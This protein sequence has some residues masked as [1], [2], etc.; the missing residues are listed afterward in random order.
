MTPCLYCDRPARERGMCHRHYQRWRRHGDPLV[1]IRA[2]LRRCMYCGKQT[3][4]ARWCSDHLDL[5][6]L[7]PMLDPVLRSPAMLEDSAPPML[8]ELREA[9]QAAREREGC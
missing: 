3:G 1:V 2:P 5:P 7:D 6:L 8:F 4:S 9:V